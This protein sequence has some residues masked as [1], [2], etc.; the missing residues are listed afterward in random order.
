MTHAGLCAGGCGKKHM[1]GLAWTC[2]LCRAEAEVA[3]L[4]A[5]VEAADAL[6]QRTAAELAALREVERAA[7][8]PRTDCYEC[9]GTGLTYPL[10]AVERNVGRIDPCSRPLCRALT[11]LDRIRSGGGQ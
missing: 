10:D 2:N 7:R 9:Y 5:K 3:R 8:Y 1:L 11:A 4:K 6:A